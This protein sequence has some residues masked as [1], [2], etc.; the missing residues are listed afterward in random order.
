MAPATGPPMRYRPGGPQPSFDKQFVRDWLESTDWDKQSPP[1]RL[2]DEI[3]AK[4]RRQY[5]LDA[6]ECLYRPAFLPGSKMLRYLTAGESHRPALTA[7]VEGFPSG[8]AHRRSSSLNP[9]VAAAAGGYGR[10]K[11]Q[12][13]ETD[14][15][16]VDSGD[17]SQR[18]HRRA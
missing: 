4:T 16:I 13:L 14:R 9:R 18:H 11:R 10:G 2:P 3:V 7:I 5:I 1:P 12:T 6:Y 15:I 8:L 17:V